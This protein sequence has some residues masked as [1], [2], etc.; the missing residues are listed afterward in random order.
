MVEGSEGVQQEE[1]CRPCEI[2]EGVDVEDE[3]RT[4]GSGEAQISEE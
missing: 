1:G 2:E 3:L 4:N